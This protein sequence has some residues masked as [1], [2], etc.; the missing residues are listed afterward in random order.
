MLA[1]MNRVSTLFIHKLVILM[2]FYHL[3]YVYLYIISRLIKVPT[4]FFKIIL[5][6]RFLPVPSSGSTR[7]NGP[8]STSSIST[9]DGS[10]MQYEQVAIA[11]VLV[12][13]DAAS[14]DVSLYVHC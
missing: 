3:L 8:K 7:V 10:E 4:H 13:N 9:L 5:G 2:Y 6:R 12:P 14:S 11:A 1:V